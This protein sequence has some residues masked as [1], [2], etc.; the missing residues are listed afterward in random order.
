MQSHN[1]RPIFLN[2]LQIR[3]PLPGLLSILHRVSGLLLFLAIPFALYLLDLAIRS[4]SGYLQANQLIS[5]P[6]SQFMLLL[7]LWSLAHH[8]L[9]GIRFLLLDV[10]VGID[11]PQFR[12]SA[13]GVIAGA[14]LL[15]AGLFWG[16]A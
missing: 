3:L 1:T 16:L 8:W 7:L 15:A 12:Y 10:D 6:L 14:P 2:L 9:A 5:A 4:E 13:F 11:K